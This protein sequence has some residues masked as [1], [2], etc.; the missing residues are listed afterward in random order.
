MVT[1]SMSSPI[2]RRMASTMLLPLL[3]DQLLI[4]QEG[5][6]RRHSLIP[7]LH[8]AF[9]VLGPV[10]ASVDGQPIPI[11]RAQRRAVLAFLL[12]NANHTVTVTELI[13]ALWETGPPATA[14]TQ[15]FAAVSAVRRA[16]RTAG[17]GMLT[18]EGSPFAVEARGAQRARGRSRRGSRSATRS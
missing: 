8:M 17:E 13:D 16:L 14:R 6:S 1:L 12:L 11:S 9:T 18:S 4:D 7:S 5:E 3:V 15:V 2:G 10:G